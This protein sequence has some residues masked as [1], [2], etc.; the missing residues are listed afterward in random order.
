MPESVAAWRAG[1]R[2]LETAAGRIFVRETDGDGPVVVL[3]HGYPSSS[4][5]FR[6]VID[7]LDR[8]TLTLDFLGFGLSDKPRPHRYTI[9]EHTDVLVEVLAQLGHRD[10]DVVAH[11]MGTSVATE[12]LARDR[13][14]ALP[15]A[16]RRVVLS[17]GGLIVSK[18]SLRPI[19]KVLLSRLGPVAAAL[20][21][22]T[23]FR[24]EFARLF[25][26]GHPLRSEEGAAQWA[27][28]SNADGHRIA[29]LLCAYVRERVAYA[30]RWHGAVR[31]WD[32]DLGLLWGLRDPVATTH[33][34]DGLRE[35]RPA[36]RV[37]E[38]P[39]LGHYPQVEDPAAFVAG[40][41]EL[42]GG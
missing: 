23:L 12:L 15:F 27:L 9:F 20:A 11:D 5:D 32:G 41:R 14:N 21:N 30:E 33:V 3:L 16:L 39:E 10:V 40:V 34:L 13:A 35:L 7:R 26:P 31:A 17:N 18:V 4:Y 29:H 38:L 36:A 1:G 2:W 28:V 42:L 22:P 24:R 8:A 25:S 6:Q 19:Q 37:V